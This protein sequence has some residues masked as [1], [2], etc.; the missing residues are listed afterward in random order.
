LDEANR[1]AATDPNFK[2]IWDSQQN[3]RQQHEKMKQLQKLP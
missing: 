2:L 3:F 1:L